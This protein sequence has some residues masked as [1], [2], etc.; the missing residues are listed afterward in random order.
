MPFGVSRLIRRALGPARPLPE[1]AFRH[2]LGTTNL[3]DLHTGPYHYFD[4]PGAVVQHRRRDYSPARVVVYGG[5]NMGD[6]LLRQI[7]K[8][9]LNG[10]FAVA[11]GVGLTFAPASPEVARLQE[12]FTLIGTRDA[13]LIPPFDYAPCASCMHPFFDAVPEPDTDV[14]LYSHR[15]YSDGLVQPPGVPVMDNHGPDLTTALLFLARGRTIVSN[16]YHGT[17]WGLLMG[18]RVLCLPFNRKFHGFR[19]PPGY[20][21][22]GAWPGHLDRAVAQP[23]YLEDCRAATRAFHNK[24]AAL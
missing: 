12:A 4:L 22:P 20:S 8:G 16:S 17:Y 21:T 23:G 2:F 13:P 11:W 3:G 5:G 14:V 9:R 19:A 1:F 10:T 6:F 24:V 7:E 15:K 18:R